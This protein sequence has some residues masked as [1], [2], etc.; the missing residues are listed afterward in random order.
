MTWA[1]TQLRQCFLD[2]KDGSGPSLADIREGSLCGM[3]AGDARNVSFLVWGDS[4]AA[5]MGPAIDVAARE[6]AITA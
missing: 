1:D 6:P 2:N 3:G 4:H 5:S